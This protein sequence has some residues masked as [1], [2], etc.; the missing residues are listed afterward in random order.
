MIT[1]IQQFLDRTT[2]YRVVLYT[3]AAIIFQAFIM[4]ALGV[5][6]YSL[7]SLSLSLATILFVTIGTHFLFKVLYGAPANSES[8]YISAL[9]AFLI[10]SPAVSFEDTLWIAIASFLLIATKYFLAY[11]HRHFFNPVAIAMVIIG[12]LGSTSVIWW[13]GSVYFLP[14]VLIAGV[15]VIYKLKRYALFFSYVFV[16][17]STVGL[18]SLYRGVAVAEAL[19]Q[20][21]ISW[22]LIFL[23]VFM[24]TEPLTTPPTKKLQ[25]IYGAIIGCLSSTPFAF[26]PLY[27]TPELAIVIGNTFSFV[28]STKSRI[29]LSL[30]EKKE[31]AKDTFELV[32]KPSQKVTYEPGQYMEWTLPIEEVDARGIRRYFTI[33]SSPLEDVIR[34]GVKRAEK[35]SAFKNKLF[36]MSEGKGLLATSVMGDFL[37]PEDKDR[38]LVFIAGGIGIT[39]FISMLRTLL[40]KKEKRDIVLFYTNK[41]E[42]EIAYKN[43][44]EDA[45]R[46]LGVRVVYV[47]SDLAAI[48][49]GWTGEKGFITQEIIETHVTAVVSSSY[50]ISGPPSMVSSY[51]TLLQSMHVCKNNITTDF[52]PGFN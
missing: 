25:A 37:L 26:P 9:I 36:Q 13:V 7:V 32:F 48:P 2:M 52:F 50:Y 47:L 31:I 29:F 14:L 39:P 42:V 1:K 20:H 33:A 22:P 23:G 17:L 35:G 3:L 34:L 38:T 8:S 46:E 11:R 44:L 4:S 43:V 18:L 6:S 21:I 5:T 19:L 49:S 27:N 12:V 51:S 28:V 30:L 45:S 10:L 15:L 40:I 24:L 16:S 41:R